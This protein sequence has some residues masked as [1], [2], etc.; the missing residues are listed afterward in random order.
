MYTIFLST[1]FDDVLSFFILPFTHLPETRLSA[2]GGMPA[3]LM[4]SM[5]E[6]LNEEK[7]KCHF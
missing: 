1:L 5:K 7:N 6:P 2:A 4:A 3:E